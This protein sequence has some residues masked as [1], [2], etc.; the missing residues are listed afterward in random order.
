MHSC[1]WSLLNEQDTV[2][3]NSFFSLFCFAH[4]VC[5]SV[6]WG[7]QKRRPLLAAAEV[8]KGVKNL[9]SCPLRSFVHFPLLF[10][11]TYSVSQQSVFLYRILM[12]AYFSEMVW[13]LSHWTLNLAFPFRITLL[14]DL[15]FV[16]L[17]LQISDKLIHSNIFE[18]LQIIAC[19]C[20]CFLTGSVCDQTSN[21][22]EG[23]E[24][25]QRGGTWEDGSD[26]WKHGD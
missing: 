6:P 14:N 20:F 26:V 24:P 11:F 9:S 13:V 1:R 7:S 23:S 4:F 2:K 3:I 25:E 19:A 12:V 5:V 22:T 17:T 10:H 15:E 8:W 21:S 18:S 16:W